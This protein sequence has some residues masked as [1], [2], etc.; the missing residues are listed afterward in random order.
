M[1]VN[2]AVV[3]AEVLAANLK[4]YEAF[5][6]G[7]LPQMN[8]LWAERAP[9]TCLH[10][11]ATALLGRKAVMR[12]WEQLLAGAADLEL[13]CEQASVSVSGDLAI[14]ICYEAAEKEPA[15]LAATNVFVRED[16]EWRMA[17]HHAGPLSNPLSRVSVAALAN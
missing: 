8:A 17:H 5:S 12:S 9:V 6:A 1:S 13:R 11:G 14:V 7:S 4:F 10:P 15:H 3:D 16:G 2:A